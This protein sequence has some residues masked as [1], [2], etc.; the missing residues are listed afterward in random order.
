M[1]LVHTGPTPNLYWGSVTLEELRAH[2]LYTGLPEAPAS[3][4]PAMYR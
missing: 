3:L 2:N 4:E 1:T